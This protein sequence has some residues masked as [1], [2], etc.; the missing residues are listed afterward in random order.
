MVK[1]IRQISLRLLVA[2]HRVFSREV[3]AGWRRSSRQADDLSG[4]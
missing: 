4:R 3:P 1:A 2:L